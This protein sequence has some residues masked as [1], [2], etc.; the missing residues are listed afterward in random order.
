MGQTPGHRVRLH[1]RDDGF[2]VVADL[3][4]RRLRCCHGEGPPRS[5]ARHSVAVFSRLRCDGRVPFLPLIPPTW[6]SPLNYSPYLF[7]TGLVLQDKHRARLI[8]RGA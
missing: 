1:D 2:H 4:Q 6:L 8:N 7:E 5:S 3:Q